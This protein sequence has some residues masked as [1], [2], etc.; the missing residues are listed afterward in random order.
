[1][2]ADTSFIIDVMDGH[3]DAVAKLQELATRGEMLKI[4]T[5]TIFELWSGIVRSSKPSHEKEKVLAVINS[6]PF[7][8]LD[9]ESAEGAGRIDGVLARKGLS[10]EPEDCMIAGIARV[11]NETILTHNQKHFRRIH[12]IPIEDY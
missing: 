3:A 12:G 9:H 6:Q 10:I 8:V 4:T 2:I 5:P 11:C 1:M 7:L